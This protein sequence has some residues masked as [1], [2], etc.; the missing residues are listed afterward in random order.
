M[1]IADDLRRVQGMLTDIEV[2]QERIARLESQMVSTTQ[3]IRAM[4]GGGSTECDKLAAQLARLEELRDKLADKIEA[5]EATV[6]RVELAVDELP[7]TQ[8]LIIQLRY[9]EGV[10]WAGIAEVMNYTREWCQRLA[11][12]AIYAIENKPLKEFTQSH[13]KTC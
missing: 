7:D 13:I 6:Q 11:G 4:P 9:F 3:R 12:D 8:R 10:S 5:R 2:Y 1:S